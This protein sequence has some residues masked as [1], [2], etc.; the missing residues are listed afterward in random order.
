MWRLRRLF[1][2]PAVPDLSDLL[3]YICPH[4]LHRFCNLGQCVQQLQPLG[5]DGCG[6]LVLCLRWLDRRHR[7]DRVPG[8]LSSRPNCLPPPP[9]TQPRVASPPPFWFQGRR[10]TRLRKRGGWWS[11]FGRRDRHSGTLGILYLGDGLHFPRFCTFTNMHSSEFFLVHVMLG[12]L[13]SVT[14]AVLKTSPYVTSLGDF[15]ALLSLVYLCSSD[16]F[17]LITY[18]GFA[19]W[20]RSLHSRLT[21][22]SFV[23]L[24]LLYRTF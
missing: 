22:C 16:I 18:V 9:H 8:F 20:V 6:Y 13:R 12:F 2:G 10:H 11:Q 23:F 4:Q 17:R 7:A 21:A 14:N 3:G 1:A 15:Q 19:T 5:W 24:K